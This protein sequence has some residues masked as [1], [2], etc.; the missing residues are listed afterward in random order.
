MDMSKIDPQGNTQSHLA[1]FVYEHLLAMSPSANLLQQIKVDPSE[2]FLVFLFA[3][4]YLTLLK[5]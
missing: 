1:G 3:L 4:F 5:S 2:D